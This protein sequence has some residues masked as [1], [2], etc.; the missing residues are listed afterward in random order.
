MEEVKQ[1]NQSPDIAALAAALAK[2][3]G[4]IQNAVKDSTNPH[5]KSAY[6]DLASVWEAC[7]T[8]LS[9][10]GIA[11]VQQPVNTAKGLMLWTTLI[12]S[13]GQWMRGELPI[14][15][16]QNTPQGI[17]SAITYMRRYGLAAMAG[18]APSED[19]D[20]NE[21]SKRPEPKQTKN[22]VSTEEMD[23]ILDGI[24]SANSPVEFEN[25]RAKARAAHFRMDK[26]QQ[27]RVGD[28]IKSRLVDFPDAPAKPQSNGAHGHA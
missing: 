13:S 20:G 7:R 14:N 4:E 27:T 23:L 8:Q 12:H 18:V 19:D 1:D 17:G 25:A 6:A 3:Q 5:F 24:S 16:T 26:T 28:L 11:V 2:A 21:A 10:N 22:P 15:P 9:V